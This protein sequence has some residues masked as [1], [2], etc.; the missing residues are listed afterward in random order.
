MPSRLAMLVDFDYFFAQC[1]EKRNPAIKD[2]PVVV[3]VYSGRSEDGGAVSTANYIAR[4]Y[5]VKSGIPIFL[6]KKKLENVDAVFLP[7]DHKFY[8]E[9]SGRI[10][11]ILK[12]YA[13]SFEQ[14]G[15]DEAYMD[16]N[17]RVK[18]D[19]GD[20][21]ILAIEIKKAV[22]VREGITCSIGIG[23]NKLVAK[24]ASDIQ[25][26]DGLTVVKP[27]EVESFLAPLPVDSLLGVGRKTFEKMQVLGIVTIG[28]LAK[29]D[30][31]R[32]VEVF[33]KRGGTY[34]HEAALGKDDTPVQEKGD[35]ESISRI[36]TLKEDTQDLVRIL[37]MTDTLCDAVYARVAQRKVGFKS[38]GVMAV[39]VDMSVRS[40]AKT[41]E[42][43]VN[44]L[45]TLKKTVKELFEKLLAECE[46]KARRVG[47]K[48]AGF[49]EAEGKQRSL[50]DFLG[51]DC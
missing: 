29:Y 4:R 3:G 30:V 18:G 16:V 45:G 6:A 27:E 50:A 40:R 49:A 46:L 44:D 42:M 37:E 5:G 7:V 15:V 14:V 39:L 10:M 21:R 11:E 17:Q 26:P 23:P 22:K 19:F 47:V 24:I 35:V 13:D 9:V 32:L 36:A 28:D 8:D 1:E 33:G 31:E 20:A 48:V 34:F 43:P 51:R 38:V 12:G 25:K 2:K 41:F